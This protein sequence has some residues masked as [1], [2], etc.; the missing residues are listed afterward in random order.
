MPTKGSTKRRAVAKFG[1]GRQLGQQCAVC[2]EDFPLITEGTLVHSIRPVG[3]EP[4]TV[5]PDCMRM[6]RQ[7]NMRCPICRSNDPP[8][9]A[10][11]EKAYLNNL[12]RLY[13]TNY[14][15]YTNQDFYRLNDRITTSMLRS[16]SHADRNRLQATLLILGNYDWNIR[17][18][19][20]IPLQHHQRFMN[21]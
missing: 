11:Q 10:E 15:F 14:I 4:H 9:T 5:C 21:V 3:S 19:K 17:G 20:K 18:V 16:S 2:M 6:I 7:M 1:M 8:P 13:N 12:C